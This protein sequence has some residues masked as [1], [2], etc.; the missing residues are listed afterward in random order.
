MAELEPYA[1]GHPSPSDFRILLLFCACATAPHAVIP[2]G[3]AAGAALLCGVARPP[4]LAT[5][6]AAGVMTLSTTT[7]AK[8]RSA[9]RA[10]DTGDG[11]FVFACGTGYGVLIVT[12]VTGL[13]AKTV[14]FRAIEHV[15]H[16]RL[17]LFYQGTIQRLTSIR[18]AV[19]RVC[20]FSQCADFHVKLD[21][22]RDEWVEG[23]GCG[24]ADTT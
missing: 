13:F 15:Q 19:H 24:H 3:P 6:V 9:V 8:D 16:G 11:A 20:Q 18:R 12:G 10:G 23:T 22:Y 14:T 1:P 17:N 4:A 7:G 5:T 2:S 21:P